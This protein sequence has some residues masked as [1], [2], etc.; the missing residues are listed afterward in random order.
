MAALAAWSHERIVVPPESVG[1]FLSD[2]ATHLAECAAATVLNEA[3]L[4]FRQFMDR[5]GIEC[6][7]V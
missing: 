5:H 2:F 6:G 4:M 3:A 1:P 7:A